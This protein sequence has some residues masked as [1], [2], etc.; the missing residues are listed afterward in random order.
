MKKIHRIGLST[1]GMLIINN[2]VQAANP[3][4]EL[5]EANRQ[6]ED[7][8]SIDAPE[9]G[10]VIIVIA[11]FTWWVST[12]QN[13]N[14]RTAY[15]YF[16]GIICLLAIT[17]GK[18]NSLFYFLVLS[19][20]ITWFFGK[21]DTTISEKMNILNKPNDGLHKIAP[22]VRHGI[23]NGDAANKTHYE[24]L[25]VTPTASHEIIEASYNN[26]I[27]R[28]YPDGSLRDPN[29]NLLKLLN[30]AY[31]TLSE[32]TKRTE[33]DATLANIGTESSRNT[34]AIP[35]K[36]PEPEHEASNKNRADVTHPYTSTEEKGNKKTIKWGLYI[37]W[38]VVWFM[39][40]SFIFVPII[41]NNGAIIAG[42][43]AGINIALLMYGFM[44]IKKRFTDKNI[45]DQNI[46]N[47]MVK[48]AL[49]IASLMV[50]IGIFSYIEAQKTSPDQTSSTLAADS[51]NQD[52]NLIAELVRQAEKGD[53]DAFG[54][55]ITLAGEGSAVAQNYLANAYY[56]GNGVAQDYTQ[57]VYWYRKAADQKFSP[58]QNSLGVIYQTGQGVSLDYTQ[59]VNWYRKAADQGLAMAQYNLGAMYQTGKGVSLDYTQAV[60]WYRKAADQ[61]L[62]TAQYYLGIMYQTGEGVSLDYTQAVYWYRKAADQG[63]ADAQTALEYTSNH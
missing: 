46:A 30:Q 21:K 4:A 59:A 55:I 49:G 35:T 36:R 8:P 32:P 22:I 41:K 52:P 33:Y 7:S 20:A 17:L 60:Y 51:R 5:E 19:G 50:A 2:T 38:F 57:S 27:Q 25:Q 45:D 44:F 10:T 18:F 58:A 16:V 11:I 14:S 9:L 62:A 61:G 13:P 43:V 53:S 23:N 63:L 31:E 39:L 40:H 28:F 26:F 12:F 48:W 56:T 47:P 3:Q 24:V 15:L 54:Q 34:G 37:G 42:L 29:D 6:N 1:A